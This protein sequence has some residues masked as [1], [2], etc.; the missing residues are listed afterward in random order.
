LNLLK[1]SKPGLRLVFWF[2]VVVVVVVVVGLAL[3]RILLSLVSHQ[4]V[5][6]LQMFKHFLTDPMVGCVFGITKHK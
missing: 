2:F 5:N 1:E 4:E 6:C 3:F